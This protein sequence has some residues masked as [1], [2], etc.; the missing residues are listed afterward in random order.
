MPLSPLP[1]ESHL[2]WACTCHFMTLWVS[3]CMRPIVSGKQ[4]F[5]QVFYQFYLLQ[6]FHHLF[7]IHLWAWGESYD[8]SINLWLNSPK[9]LIHW[10]LISCGFSVNYCLL[11]EDSLMSVEWW[12]DLWI[13]PYVIRYHSIVM[14]ILKNDTSRFPP[15]ESM[16]YLVLGSCPHSHCH[17]WVPSL[18]MGL[19]PIKYS[20]LLS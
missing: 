7:C 9:A 10:K 20:W 17:I 11:K 19:K 2:V 16:T 13:Q 1:S 15:L 14:S 18:E 5:L 12:T 4:G 6:S 3:M 8:V